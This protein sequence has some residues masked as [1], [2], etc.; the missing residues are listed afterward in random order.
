MLRGRYQA[1]AELFHEAEPLARGNVE[2][3]RVKGKLGELAFK[4]GDMAT[5]TAAYETALRLLGRFIPQFNTHPVSLPGLGSSSPNP[6][7]VVAWILY[8]SD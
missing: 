7:H 3:A 2:L 1:A 5:A 8:C 4:R 6:A